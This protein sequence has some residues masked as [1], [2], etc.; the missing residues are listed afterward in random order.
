[1]TQQRS[2]IPDIIAT[3]SSDPVLWLSLYSE[4]QWAAKGYAFGR[5]LPQFRGLDIQDAP[6]LAREIC[7]NSD[8]RGFDP[9]CIIIDDLIT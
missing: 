4:L 5:R 2:P 9:H 8:I 6:R 1:M 7:G 3:I